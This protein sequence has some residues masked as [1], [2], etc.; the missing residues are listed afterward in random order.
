MPDVAFTNPS[1]E[2]TTLAAFRGKPLLVNLWA[3]WCAPC[4]AEMPTL[5]KLAV[6]RGDALRVLV[7]S[8]DLGGAA[9]VRPFFAKNDYIALQPYLDPDL[10]LSLAYG[11]NLPTTILYD[12]AGREV[13]RVTG[14]LDWTGDKAA[15]LLAEGL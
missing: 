11:A 2:K 5:D 6:A 15:K 10:N 3:T 13:W 12:A 7:V 1:G 4:I 8:Q 14:G 9:Q